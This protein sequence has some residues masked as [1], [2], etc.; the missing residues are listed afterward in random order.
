MLKMVHEQIAIVWDDGPRAFQLSLD[1]DGTEAL[2][3]EMPIKVIT[4]EGA[5][6]P[7]ALI[8]SLRR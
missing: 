7:G 3:V 4:L 5:P 6:Q 1:P 8:A 2:L